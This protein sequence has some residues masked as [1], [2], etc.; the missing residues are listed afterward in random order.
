MER[1]D[2]RNGGR[3]LKHGRAKG[4]EVA[5]KTIRATLE[6]NPLWRSVP[7]NSFAVAGRR[8]SGEPI[9]ETPRESAR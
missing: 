1:T 7:V 6:G 8:R 2:L 9:P 4:L 3:P 5:L